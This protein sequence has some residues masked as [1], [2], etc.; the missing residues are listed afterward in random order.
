M[1]RLIQFKDADGRMVGVLARGQVEVEVFTTG[2]VHV[3]VFDPVSYFCG[4]DGQYAVIEGPETFWGR[5]SVEFA[6]VR[7]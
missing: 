5:G 2:D 7:P 1:L 4:P 3:S 6:G